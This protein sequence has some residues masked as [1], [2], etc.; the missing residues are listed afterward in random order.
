MWSFFI[1]MHFWTPV[2]LMEQSSNKVDYTG[3]QGSIQSNN[4]LILCQH[5]KLL[6][7]IENVKY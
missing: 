1:E 6:A 2:S 4:L 7:A 3:Y 5:G